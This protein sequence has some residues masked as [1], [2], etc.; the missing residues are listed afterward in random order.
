MR[1]LFWTPE[2]L[3]DRE[4]IYNHIES[5]NPASALALDE[6][7][8]ARASGLTKFPAIGRPGRVEGTR[9]LV[10]HRRY[11]LVYATTDAAIQILRVL[12]TARQRHYPG[13]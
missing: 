5:E 13:S 1:S 12:H 3:Q 8:V 10:V 7:F 9:E 6:L 2:A 4:T 11:L